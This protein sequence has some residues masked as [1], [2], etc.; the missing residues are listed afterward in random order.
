MI[1]VRPVL[2]SY[3]YRESLTPHR[4]CLHCTVSFRKVFIVSPYRKIKLFRHSHPKH[5]LSFEFCL[6]TTGRP[7]RSSTRCAPL[8]YGMPMKGFTL[9]IYHI[10]VLCLYLRFQF[11]V[12][13]RMQFPTTQRGYSARMHEHFYPFCLGSPATPLGCPRDP[14]G[15]GVPTEPRWEGAARP[16][17][18]F[19]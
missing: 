18:S 17:R 5:F 15:G 16:H 13:S 1:H 19:N 2:Q 14:P 6:R 8:P 3:D 9:I 4:I 10:F 12:L 11:P 7:L